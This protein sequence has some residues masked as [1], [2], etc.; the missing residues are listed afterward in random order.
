[1]SKNC[2]KDNIIWIASLLLASL[3]HV[4]DMS[5]GASASFPPARWDVLAN[6]E[7]RKK[8]MLELEYNLYNFVWTI[9]ASSRIGVLASRMPAKK[10]A[11]ITS[12]RRILSNALFASK[13]IIFV[14]LWSTETSKSDYVIYGWPQK[15]VD[16][17]H[18]LSIY[19]MIPKI[20]TFF[21]GIFRRDI[22]TQGTVGW[23]PKDWCGE[24]V[25]SKPRRLTKNQKKQ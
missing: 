13:I 18:F 21:K 14:T 19:V 6:V 22:K 12:W 8:T 24:G 5:G 9:W 23:L 3:W 17:C 4:S 1:M 10:A 16:V 11:L 15:S 2:Q 20:N 25:G 7:I